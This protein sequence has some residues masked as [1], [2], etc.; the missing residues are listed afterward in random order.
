MSFR[1]LHCLL[2]LLIG[3][4]L[5]ADSPTDPRPR[6]LIA[7]LGL[8]PLPGESGF[9]G[10]IGRSPQPIQ[11][12]DRTLA[13]QSQIYYLLTRELPLNYLHWL[14][15]DDTQV[16]LEGGP[17]DYYI[18]HPDGR[19]E[20]QVLGRNLAAGERLVIAV[21]GNCWKSLRLHPGVSHA[22]MANVLSPEW[23]PDRAKIG[24]GSPFIQRYRASAPWATDSFLRE[25]IGPNFSDAK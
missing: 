24:A 6:E 14:A 2:F 1:L 12:G 21:P 11:T 3:R 9:F 16:L 25:L 13:A 7:A 19:V 22:L 4:A 20:K 17:V 18:F 5:F 8:E 10:L 15:S 23:T